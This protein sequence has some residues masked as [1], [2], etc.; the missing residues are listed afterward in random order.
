M[1]LRVLAAVVAGAAL[2]TA[3][4][5]TGQRAAGPATDGAVTAAPSSSGTT[6]TLTVFAAASLKDTFTALGTQFEAANPGTQVTF[7]FAGSSDL[8]QQIVQ[9]APADVFAAASDATMKTVSDAGQTAAAPA[10]FAKNTLQIAVAPGNPKGI[11]SFADLAK[12]EFKVVVC[13][14]GVPCGDA[15]LKVETATQIDVQPVSEE[16]DVKSTL[17]KVQSGDADAGLVYVT[18]V[19]AAKGAVQGVAFPEAAQAATNYPIAVVKTSKQ[20]AL[21]Q[22]FEALVTGQA[23]QQVLQAAGFQAP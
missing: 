9:G 4:C 23:G 7:N 3:G 6:T 10:P 20:A 21:A 15:E 5:G 13:A 17:S 16:P 19:A 18:D 12:P 1:K 8:A 2:L 22:K 11:A 14:K